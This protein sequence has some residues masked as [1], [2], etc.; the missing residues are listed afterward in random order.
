MQTKVV[1][2]FFTVIMCQSVPYFDAEKAFN[3]IEKQCEFYSRISSTK[4]TAIRH[5][6]IYGPYDK[7]DAERSHVFG[8]TISKVLTE[9]GGTV[10][11]I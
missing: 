6:N 1:I 9:K 3:Y 11:G 2:L 4:Y 10:G 8:A 7:F 5:S